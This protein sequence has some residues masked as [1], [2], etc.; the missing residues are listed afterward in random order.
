MGEDDENVTEKCVQS[1]GVDHTEAG[2]DAHAAVCADPVNSSAD[3]E[4]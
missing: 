1:N 2:E 3:A 4:C